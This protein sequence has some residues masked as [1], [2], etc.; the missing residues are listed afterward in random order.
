MREARVAFSDLTCPQ[1]SGRAFCPALSR[2]HKS[3]AFFIKLERDKDKD[4]RLNFQ[5]YFN[6]LFDSLRN[7]E[8]AFNHLATSDEARSNILFQKLDKDNDG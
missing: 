6:G 3:L 5:E 4:G 7:V 1:L 8:E 2:P